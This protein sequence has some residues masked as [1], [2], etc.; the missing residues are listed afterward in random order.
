MAGSGLASSHGRESW[1]LGNKTS[2]PCLPLGTPH[3]EAL[4]LCIRYQLTT[5]LRLFCPLNSLGYNC[6]DP[7]GAWPPCVCT[8][9]PDLLPAQEAQ[10][11]N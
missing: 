5:L 8:G 1:V 9:I 6:L 3:Q 4:P 10:G 11:Q 2:H 7:P